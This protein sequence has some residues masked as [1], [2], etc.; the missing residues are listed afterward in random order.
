MQ[1]GQIGAQ[2][3]RERVGV[4]HQFGLAREAMAG[5]DPRNALHDEELAAGHVCVAA[6]EKRLRHDDAVRMRGNAIQRTPA[7]A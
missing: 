5:S 6:K 4:R 2:F 1:A 7:S 3:L